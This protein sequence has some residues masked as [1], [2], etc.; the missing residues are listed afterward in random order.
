MR[1]NRYSRGAIVARPF[2]A[3]GSVDLRRRDGTGLL[4]TSDGI[5]RAV[6][7]S[8]AVG[9]A[10]AILACI[11]EDLDEEACHRRGVEVV[12]QPATEGS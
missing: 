1:F 2:D 7:D 12:A 10:A 3:E 6:I 5:P 9:D 8:I 11:S 4:R